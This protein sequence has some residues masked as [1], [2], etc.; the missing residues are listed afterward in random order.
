MKRKSEVTSL[1]KKLRAYIETTFNLNIV[2]LHTDQGTEYISNGMKEY[3]Q[4]CGVTHITVHGKT[5]SL[6]D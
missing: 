4:E 6:K 1:F 5:H 3:M 2:I